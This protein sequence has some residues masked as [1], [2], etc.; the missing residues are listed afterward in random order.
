MSSYEGSYLLQFASAAEAES[1]YRYYVQYADFAEPDAA[2][3][4]MAS[5][6]V[7]VQTEHGFSE[8]TSESNSHDHYGS[9][10]ENTIPEAD[11]ERIQ[12]I[13]NVK[14]QNAFTEEVNP[15]SELSDA[16]SGDLSAGSAPYTSGNGVIALIDTGV[17][18]GS[19]VIES[20]S[21]LG[22][23]VKDDN[24]HGTKMAA[25]IISENPDARILS[26]KALDA[27]GNGTPSSVYAAIRYAM[28]RKVSVINLSLSGAKK[29]DSSA[30]AEIIKEA[31][32]AGI[33]VIGAA[34]NNSRDAKYYIPGCIEEA[35]IAGAADSDGR[36]TGG[37]N[38]GGT[39][40]YYV[41]A[42]STSEAA[43]RLSGIYSTTGSFAK[44]GAVF[45]SAL[46]GSRSSEKEQSGNGQ[47]QKTE[48]SASV[49]V[50][51]IRE[52]E[53]GKII[54]VDGMWFLAAKDFDTGVP[55]K[56]INSNAL[57]GGLAAADA[58]LSPVACQTVN[59]SYGYG[60]TDKEVGYVNGT[61]GQGRFDFG[62]IHSGML[63][64]STA[65]SRM[66]NT[67]TEFYGAA[68]DDAFCIEGGQVFHTSWQKAT[69]LVNTWAKVTK[70]NTHLITED[71]VRR[72]ALA[73]DYAYAHNSTH[74]DRYRDA[75]ACVYYIL[76]SLGY[77]KLS[78]AQKNAVAYADK[79]KNYAT[80]VYARRMVGGNNQDTAVF[81]VEMNPVYLR[82]QKTEQAGAGSTAG[83]VYELWRDYPS[84]KGGTGTGISLII[85]SDGY[86]QTVEL[87]PGHDYWYHELTP[88]KSGRYVKDDTW[89]H[90]TQYQ[91]QPYK[92]YSIPLTERTTD[93][94]YVYARIHKSGSYAG[95]SVA[96]A[97]YEIWQDNTK[98]NGGIA[99]GKSFVIQSDGYSNTVELV[100]GHTY[101]YHEMSGP[102]NGNY[103]VDDTWY[104][105]TPDQLSAAAN[106]SAPYQIDIGEPDKPAYTYLTKTSSNTDVT[107]NNRCYSLDGAQFYLK[108]TTPTYH[109]I[110]K[111]SEKAID[112][113]AI[114]TDPG[115]NVEQYNKHD[116]LGQKF[117]LIS[118]STKKPIS[119]SEAVNNEFYIVSALKKS[120]ALEA[121]YGGTTNG[122]NVRLWPWNQSAAQKFKLESVGDGYY[123]IVNVNSGLVLDVEAASK[124][125][126]ANVHLWTYVGDEN[127]KWKPEDNPIHYTLTTDASGNTPKTQVVADT[128]TVTETKAP[129]G[130]KVPTE[131]IPDVT[132]SF[133]NT[134]NNPAHIQV[135]DTPGL[136][137]VPILL[138]KRDAETGKDVR[139]V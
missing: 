137:P 130:Y 67:G 23:D 92:T 85:G 17:S 106:E 117:Y 95:G 42:E 96:G 129:K 19:N 22:D 37:T 80:V 120:M 127:Q 108:N 81:E 131:G 35:V 122:T 53:Q 47:S 54:D 11:N 82:L 138:Q 84:G 49:S 94:A 86:S 136:D 50:K 116:G 56:T 6:D 46:E 70:T 68:H 118:A 83:A 99:T 3:I 102:T 63:N 25:C 5:E 101:W 20:V 26:I 133:D 113:H 128:Y 119:A 87:E 111:Y 2:I 18:P 14:E 90:I 8:I 21:M 4:Q 110:N 97:T 28:E 1:A 39:V 10:P 114:S 34:G 15:L 134:E 121:A 65:Q 38:Y 55:W 79:Y 126:E 107:N 27:N 105:I 76:G 7:E 125:N 89:H 104:Q 33:T 66:T 43:A 98:E 71:E 139:R 77:D 9:E 73:R 36:M 29:A 115:T 12:N 100:S 57:S 112:L 88:P 60:T 93:P 52:T 74:A 13:T 123:K 31:V 44:Q 40:D 61:G 59:H 109:I 103:A 69:D 132:V 62:G 24:G 48:N 91:L 72:M 45:T 30:I 16:V 41:A 64:V 51:V 75:Q 58:D 135:E 32:K 78:E 124:D